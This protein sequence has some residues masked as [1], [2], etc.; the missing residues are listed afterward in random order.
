MSP[1]GRLLRTFHLDSPT[2]VASFCQLA[3]RSTA[4]ILGLDV[5]VRH[6]GVAISDSA[7]VASI[8]Q[9]PEKQDYTLPRR[10][11]R[12]SMG[13]FSLARS[14]RDGSSTQTNII[15][16]LYEVFDKPDVVHL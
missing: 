11:I 2:D 6:I 7:Y 1:R 10:L 14:T 3:L 5:G 9:S 8:L 4:P 16:Q 13:I 12:S 15:C